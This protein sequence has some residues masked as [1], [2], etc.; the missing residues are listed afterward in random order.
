VHGVAVGRA[1]AK[2]AHEAIDRGVV[3][4]PEVDR[5]CGGAPRRAR[6]RDGAHALARLA[7]GRDA[8]R[9][10]GAERLS[11][12]ARGFA[13]GERGARLVDASSDLRRAVR[14]AE[15][16]VATLNTAI[17]VLA[18]V[19]R[20]GRA[21]SK[22]ARELRS[23]VRAVTAS[24]VPQLGLACV[25]QSIAAAR[26]EERGRDQQRA[27]P[28]RAVRRHAS[29]VAARAR[30]VRIEATLESQRHGATGACTRARSCAPRSR[31]ARAGS[32]NTTV[33]RASSTLSWSSTAAARASA[34]A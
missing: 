18:D 29:I 34:R 8:R 4:D 25:R 12:V 2:A 20:L 10:G 21:G 26:A 27:R 24:A 15:L 17:V 33:G 28:R 3:D 16:L 19:P 23:C 1:R 30:C 32:L 5:T 31:T 14:T 6:C 9:A 7:V 13:R 11:G 22:V